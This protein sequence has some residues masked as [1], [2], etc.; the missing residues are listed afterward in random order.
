MRIEAQ[1][2]NLDERKELTLLSS[3]DLKE[4]KIAASSTEMRYYV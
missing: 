1:E 2:R 3:L 4:K